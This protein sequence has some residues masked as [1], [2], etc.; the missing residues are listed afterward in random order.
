MK[1][2]IVEADV[3]KAAR[4]T[5]YILIDER[6]VIT[7]AAADLAKEKGVIFEIAKQTDSGSLFM[8]QGPNQSPVQTVAIASDHGG[9]AMKT[10]LIPYIERLGYK[11][12]DMGPANDKASDYPDYAFKV[13]E[14]VSIGKVDRGIMIDSVGIGSAMAANR[15]KGV[16]AAKCNNAFEARSSREHNYANYLTFGAKIIGI[17]IVKD[18]VKVFLETPGGAIRHQKRVEKILEYPKKD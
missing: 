5:K 16:L 3:R 14:M 15:V 2:V 7:P 10:E 9:F 1:K 13:A 6:T 8:E 17:E 11:V 12:H 4:E 18:I